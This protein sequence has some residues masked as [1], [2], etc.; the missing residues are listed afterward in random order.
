MS[1]IYVAGKNLDR[2]RTV[3]D[4][5]TK[6]GHTITFDWVADINNNTN[7]PEKAIQEREAVI[8]ADILV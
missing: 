8:S 3:M 7:I 2:A 1:K 4:T 6:L 5:L